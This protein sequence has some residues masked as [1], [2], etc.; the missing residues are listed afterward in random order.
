M[1][2]TP[3]QL[4]SE[5]SLHQPVLLDATLE[6][7]DPKKGES[8][9]DLTAGYGGHARAV[10]DRTKAPDHA[11][12]VDRDNHAIQTLGDLAEQGVCLIY[13]DFASAAYE[14]AESGRRF[15]M[16]LVDLGV[17]SPQLDKKQR[18]FSFAPG[19]LDMRM[20]QREDKTAADIVNRYS[21][22]RLTDVIVRYGEERPRQ[23]ARIAQAI[24]EARPIDSTDTLASV[25]LKTHRGPRQKAHP[26][27][28]T[29][30]AIRIELNQELEQIK[31]LLKGL[32]GLL[33]PGGRVVVISFHSL[34]DRLVKDYFHEQSRS[35]YESEL[36][37]LIKRPIKGSQEDV[38]NP[39]ARSAMLRAVVKNK[40]KGA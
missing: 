14:L 6:L 21:K 2:N 16:I 30:Q 35:G 4:Q 9:L 29:F 34:E 10:L 15:D 7:L 39:R 33:T 5:F 12:L 40:K 36:M 24:V 3:Q 27:T 18:G 31:Q 37:E 20:D 11:T 13:Q 8:Y 38:H 25:I 22:E 32:P 17:S 26:A 19:P 1:K 23:A 28:R